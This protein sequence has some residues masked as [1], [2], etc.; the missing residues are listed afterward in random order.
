MRQGLDTTNVD[1]DSINS[2]EEYQ[3][4][5]DQIQEDAQVQQQSELNKNAA[6]SYQAMT[7]APEAGSAAE[8]R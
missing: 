4:I 1:Q 8:G 2:E 7:H 3:K 5:I 6:Q